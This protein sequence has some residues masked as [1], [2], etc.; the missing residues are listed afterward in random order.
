MIS[1]AERPKP[2]KSAGAESIA[3]ELEDAR[4][5]LAVMQRFLDRI[6][7]FSEIVS[8]AK[9]SLKQLQAEEADLREELSKVRDDIKSVKEL[10]SGSNDGIIKLIEPGPMAFLPLF[11]KMEKADPKTHGKNAAKWREEPVSVLRLS[12]TS[13]ELL[14]AAEILFIGQLQDR[15]LEDPQEW[16]KSV[17]GLTVAFAA[18]I[19]DKLADFASKGGAQ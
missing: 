9:D 1:T 4:A 5:E 14:Y 18:A 11:D 17:A 16:W 12:P 10:I 19:A 13:T 15:I 8:R 6:Q 3:S 7:H 2:K